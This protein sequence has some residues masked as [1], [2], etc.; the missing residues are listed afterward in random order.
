SLVWARCRTTS[1][2]VQP[3]QREGRCQPGSSR[4]TSSA[5]SS[6]C[7]SA[8]AVTTASTAGPPLRR[9]VRG[10]PARR[11][12]AANSLHGTQ[13]LDATHLRATRDVE[14]LC[15]AV[16]LLAGLRRRAAGALAL[17]HSRALLAAGGA[18][19]LGRV[20]NRALRLCRAER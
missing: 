10:V 20:G 14:P 5:E 9:T 4:P 11:P 17:R 7:W 12:L 19:L 18:R 2:T 15:L 1:A 3:S 13:E 8:S 16:Q 6:A